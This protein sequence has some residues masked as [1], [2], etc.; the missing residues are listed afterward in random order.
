MRFPPHQHADVPK[1]HA[2]IA[3]VFKE[4]GVR[5][6]HGV[7][8]RQDRLGRSKVALGIDDTQQARCYQ[9]WGHALSS[10]LKGSAHE[11]VLAEQELAEFVK[12]LPRQWHFI[13]C[14]A[15]HRM[16]LCKAVGSGRLPS[17]SIH[18]HH[19]KVTG[20]AAKLTVLKNE[21]GTLPRTAVSACA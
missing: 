16:W 12:E 13:Q 9:L 5:A 20:S 17:Q 11:A 7:M 18:R 8:K 3:L 14:P 21:P 10:Y 2:C 4:L 1:R 19:P 6:A 15:F